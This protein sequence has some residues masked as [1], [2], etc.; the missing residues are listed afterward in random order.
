V[1]PDSTINLSDEFLKTKEKIIE[2]IKKINDIINNSDYSKLSDAMKTISG[3][4][5]S[6]IP[7]SWVDSLNY[8]CVIGGHVFSNKNE[9]CEYNEENRK[10]LL[11]ELEANNEYLSSKKEL[12][13]GPYSFKR[14][15]VSDEG[16]ISL[17]SEPSEDSQ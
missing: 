7:S 14:S 16:K 5:D 2:N 15:I 1:S 11:R 17:K 6:E 4:F 10:K 3:L 13:K 12:K 8:P 9:F